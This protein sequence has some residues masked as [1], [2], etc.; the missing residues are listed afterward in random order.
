M[1]ELS[2]RL[3]SEIIA[4]QYGEKADPWGWRVAIK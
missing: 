4:I 1:G 2:Q 3:Y